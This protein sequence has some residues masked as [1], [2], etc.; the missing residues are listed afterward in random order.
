MVVEGKI[1]KEGRFWLVEFSDFDLTTQGKSKEEALEMATSLFVEASDT[2]KVSAEV[3]KT[4]GDTVSVRVLPAG[5]VI[6]LLLRR[7]RESAGLTLK[8]V[9]ARL[10]SSSINSYAAYEQGTRV[11]GPEKLDELLKAVSPDQ[12]LILRV[13]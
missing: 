5:P 3:L 2:G 1:W 13:G 8:E 10:G 9:A 12:D 7:R 4:R 6:A 11:P